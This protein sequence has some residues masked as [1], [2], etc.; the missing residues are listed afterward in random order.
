VHI[1]ARINVK[2]CKIAS[3]VANVNMYGMK[4]NKLEEK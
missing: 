1:T 3:A 4:G 2:T